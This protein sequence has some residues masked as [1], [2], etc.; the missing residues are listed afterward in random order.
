MDQSCS[1]ACRSFVLVRDQ[2]GSSAFRSFFLSG[3][4]PFNQPEGPCSCQG[5]ISLITLKVPCPFQ[6]SIPFTA[7]TIFLL[8]TNYCT[9]YCDIS[10]LFSGSNPSFFWPPCPSVGHSC[11]LLSCP[12]SLAFLKSLSEVVSSVASADT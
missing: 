2:Y 12:L 9:F 3:I 1:S 6:G 7:S 11:P 10:F 5:S 4:S 8:I